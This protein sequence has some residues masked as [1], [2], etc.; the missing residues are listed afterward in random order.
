MD[1]LDDDPTAV[2]LMTYGIYGLDYDDKVDISGNAINP[3]ISNV[4]VYLISDKYGV[5]AVR[6]ISADKFKNLVESVPKTEEMWTLLAEALMFIYGNTHPPPIRDLKA[7]ILS[8]LGANFTDFCSNPSCRALLDT[9]SGIPDLCRDL[10]ARVLQDL[11]P[12]CFSCSVCGISFGVLMIAKASSYTAD[13]LRCPVCKKSKKLSLKRDPFW[14]N[15]SDETKRSD[16]SDEN[17]GSDGSDDNK[18]SD[19]SDDDEDSDESGDSEDSDESNDDSEDSE[20]N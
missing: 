10:L 7:I 3:I 16:G 4:R 8:L 11:S 13:E 1:M 9:E 15:D 18:G 19:G 2:S 17:K 6:A 12:N 5:E 20:G 14:S